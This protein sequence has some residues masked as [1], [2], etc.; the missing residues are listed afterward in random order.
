MHEY[1]T[2]D[3][4]IPVYDEN[5]PMRKHLKKFRCDA[6]RK[7]KFHIPFDTGDGKTVCI[8]C[9]TKGEGLSVIMNER[10]VDAITAASDRINGHDNIKG[11]SKNQSRLSK[12][13]SWIKELFE[14]EF[15]VSDLVWFAAL[16]S[17]VIVLLVKAF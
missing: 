15:F 9:V 8:H 14:Y 16:A 4:T 10:T 5:D 2:F 12:I 13:K 7:D 3:H 1:K 17:A 6:C 11:K